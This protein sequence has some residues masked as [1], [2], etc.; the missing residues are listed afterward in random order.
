[1]GWKQPIYACAFDGTRYDTGTLIGWLKVVVAYAKKDPNIG[2]EFCE[3]LQQ[4]TEQA[5]P[6]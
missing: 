6:S 1:M 2:P 5:A 3:Y 4:I